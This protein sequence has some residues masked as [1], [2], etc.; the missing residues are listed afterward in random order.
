VS[1]FSAQ[2]AFDLEV[3]TVNPTTQTL[4]DR[5]VV[6]PFSTLDRRAG[7]WQ[8]RR[9]A[10]LS[11]GIQSEVGRD[12]NLLGEGLNRFT[13]D[14]YGK[15]MAN[16]AVSVFDPV[17][18]ELSYRWYCPPGGIVLDP[19][20]GGSVRG[21]V[22]GALGYRYMGVELRPEQIASNRQQQE[23]IWRTHGALLERGFEVKAA[24]PQWRQADAT[25][26]PEGD[27]IFDFIF[28]CPPYGDLEV[29]SD[30]PADLSTMDHPAFERAH[31]EAI[32]R[33]CSRL[34]PD[35]FA[36]WV[37]SDFRDKKTGHFRGFVGATVDA[38]GEAGL[39]L[40]NDHVLIDPVGTAQIRATKQ[41]NA[42]RKAVR[43]HQHFLVFVKGDPRVPARLIVPEPDADA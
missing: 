39:A 7:Y 3:E 30:D 34:K 43:I 32:R 8:D 26:I 10:W 4:F 21:V 15:A 13:D 38:F 42:Q 6:P 24:V 35:R 17:V 20:A 36:G 27:P 5:F 16:A 19:F 37:V 31:A 2:A 33:A 14:A 12:G 25:K 23:E 29:Y 18:A 22:A 11:L 41:F 9:R 28:S 40:Y 1:D